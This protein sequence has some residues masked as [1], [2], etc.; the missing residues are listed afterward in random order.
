MIQFHTY[1]ISNHYRKYDIDIFLH[2]FNH[3]D[4][5]AIVEVLPP[6]CLALHSCSD[7]Y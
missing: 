3:F 2:P 4:T 6:F 5:E 7:I 1:Q